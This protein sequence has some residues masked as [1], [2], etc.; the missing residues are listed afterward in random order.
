M[1]L[2][3]L[4]SLA[5]VAFTALLAAHCGTNP[6]GSSESGMRIFANLAKALAKP[7][8][9]N[10]QTGSKQS[11]KSMVGNA[12]STAKSLA[13]SM[14]D[15]TALVPFWLDSHG[16]INNG[17][18]SYT[19]FQIVK[20]KPSEED[21]DKLQTGR[22]EI[23]FGYNGV[24]TL[25]TLD[26]S[27]ITSIASFELIG[28]EYKTWNGETDSIH[29]KIT[30]SNPDAK[31]FKPGRSIAWGKNISPDQSRG[32]GDTAA[33]TLDSLDDVNHIQYGAGHFFDAHTG[34]MHDGDSYSFDYTLQVIHKNSTGGNPYLRYQD[35][36]GIVNF[37]LPRPNAETLYF[38]IHFFPQYER[39]G[40]IQRDGPNGPVLVDF[41]YNEKRRIG[42]ATYYNDNGKIIG[43]EN[44]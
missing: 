20:D 2:K 18:G 9:I 40:S 24:P 41:S 44:L 8:Q 31:D 5:A 11:S 12:R 38:T 39:T 23:V 1:N 21:S 7:P 42:S 3:R 13:K 30:F 6:F 10:D 22:G 33:F 26:T 32:S 36:E 34:R 14:A 15:A 43:R 28:R 25:A 27:K 19:Y 4:T 16:I 29:A 17:N 37:Y 35:N